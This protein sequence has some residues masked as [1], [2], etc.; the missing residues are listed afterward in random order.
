MLEDDYVKPDYICNVKD[1]EDKIKFGIS[2]ENITLDFKQEVELPTGAARNKAAEEL[3]LDICQ[4]ANTWGGVL[5][6]GVTERLCEASNKKTAFSTK[7]VNN[8]EQLS[9]FI[10]DKVI[11]VIHPKSINFEIN[12]FKVDGCNICSINVEPLH[13]GLACV[14]TLNPP[15]LAKYPY[16]THHGKK[17]LNPMDVERSLSVKNKHLILR[18]NELSKVTREIDIYPAIMREE[19]DKNTW[20]VVGDNAIVENISK[21]EFTLNI[22]SLRINVPYSFVNDVWLSES[23]RI[24]LFLKVTISVTSDRKK[25]NFEI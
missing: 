16:R 10:N 5:L 4:F 7:N 1:F 19:V 6:I 22:F 2:T 15:Y 17:Y 8:C 13:N 24:G 21:S 14:Y 25:L 23:G 9:C 18:L 12:N 20:E 11:P 3:A